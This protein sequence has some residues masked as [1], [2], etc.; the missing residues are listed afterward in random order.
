MNRHEFLRGLHRV[1]RP[2]NY[3]EI[4]VNDGRSLAISRVPSVAVDPAFKVVTSIS[5]DVHLVKAT[6]DDFFARKDPLLHLRPGRNP[7]RALARRDPLQML[8]GDPKL[9]LSFIDG[10]H[11]FEF[12]LRD[13]MNVEK[14]ARWNS[15][16]VL[17]DMLPRN[18]DEAARDRHTREW[19]GD[20]Y[21]VATVLRR[22]RP[23]LLVVEVD[24]APTG[25]LAVFGA[26]PGSTVLKEKY[27]SILAEYVTADPQD[28][29]DEVMT[30]KRAVAPQALLGADFW[31]GLVRARN[32]NRSRAAFTGLRRSIE[33]VTG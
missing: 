21:K 13:F 10:M 11:L 23:D 17:D 25:V 5:C 32:L 2:R 16:I 28:V 3:L 18:V 15:V 24:T 20:V 19:T 22:F 4:G 27:E 6:S 7:F 12:A 33:R 31:P 8:G 29:P 26:D 30:R 1:Y 9:E 14:H